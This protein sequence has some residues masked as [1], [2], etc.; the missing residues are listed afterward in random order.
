MS[1]KSARIP[2]RVAD[3]EGQLKIH[4]EVLT[5]HAQEF[6]DHADWITS[7]HQRVTDLENKSPTSNPVAPTFREFQLFMRGVVWTVLVMAVGVALAL[8]LRK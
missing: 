8:V 2:K 1:S 5:L 4:H 7:V 6:T 3:P